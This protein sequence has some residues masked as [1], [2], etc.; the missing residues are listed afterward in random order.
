MFD[1]T[2][3]FTV[4]FLCLFTLVGWGIG[5]V[6]VKHGKM[7]LKYVKNYEKEFTM[8]IILP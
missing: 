6:L 4:Q 2:H 1:Q 3:M 7:L 5:H 8:N